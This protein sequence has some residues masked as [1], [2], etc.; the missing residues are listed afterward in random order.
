[1]FSSRVNAYA[2]AC[3]ALVL[4][5]GALVLAAVCIVDRLRTTGHPAIVVGGA[6]AFAVYVTWEAVRLHRAITADLAKR[7]A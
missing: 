7:D 6:A 5:S 3:C 1:M 4:M 2:L